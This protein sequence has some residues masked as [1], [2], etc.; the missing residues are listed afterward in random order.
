MSTL[1][2]I[3]RFSGHQGAIYDADWDESTQSW[4]TAGGDGVIAEW[5]TDQ[6]SEGKALLHHDQAFFTIKSHREYRVAGAENG[7]LFLWK[8]LESSS[9]QR[10]T[11]HHG[12]VFSVNWLNDKVF[13]SGGG[14]ER[15]IRWNTGIVE[16]DWSL[17]NTRKIRCIAIGSSSVFIGSSSGE[18]ILCSDLDSKDSIT[19]GRRFIGHEGG[20]YDAI[21]HEAKKVWISGG[22]DGHLKVWDRQGTL[23]L[24]F[25]AHEQSI[26]R[27]RTDG[28]KLWTSS[29]DKSIKAWDLKDLRPILKI[30]SK[31]GGSN[32]SINALAIGGLQKNEVLFGGDD[33]LVRK[34]ST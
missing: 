29:R 13:Y 21:W 14:D 24:K 28:K 1:E 15:V 16:R 32:R 11:A 33:R 34:L 23:I 22:R 31:E 18:V 19:N 3:Q 25:P 9:I 6:R 4:L 2:T 26:Y 5:K 8:S 10:M 12:G 17:K 20:T 27:L 30:S 7:E